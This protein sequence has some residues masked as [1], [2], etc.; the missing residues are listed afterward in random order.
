MNSAFKKMGTKED[1]YLGEAQYC[2]EDYYKGC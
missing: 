1:F 2:Q